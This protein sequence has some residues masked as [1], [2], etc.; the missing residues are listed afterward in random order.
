MKA[1]QYPTLLL[2]TLVLKL[3]GDSKFMRNEH[4]K[5]IQLHYE[6]HVTSATDQPVALLP[7]ARY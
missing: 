1:A 2:C 7:A 3:G 5:N 6:G 4:M